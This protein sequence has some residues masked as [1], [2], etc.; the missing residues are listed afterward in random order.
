MDLGDIA[1]TA[2]GVQIGDRVAFVGRAG[3]SA[4]AG[5]TCTPAAP[6]LQ[7]PT[8]LEAL[9]REHAEQFGTVSTDACSAAAVPAA[10]C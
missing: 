4:Q 2:S 8:E 1:A 3:D 6:A 9:L 10:A 5:V 7:K